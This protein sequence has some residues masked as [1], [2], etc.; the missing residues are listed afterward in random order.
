MSD[1][2]VQP[3]ASVRFI[4]G[5]IGVIL[6][7]A[8]APAALQA[9]IVRDVLASVGL[10]KPSPPPNPAAGA[11]VFPRQGFACCNLHRDGSSINDGN[12][13][14]YPLIPAGTAIEVLKY[15]RNEASIKIN[16][17]ALRLVHDYGRDQETLDQWVNKIVVNVDPT[18]RI[19]S[20]PPDVQAAIHDGKILVG[21]TREQAIVAIGYPLTSENASLDEPIWR[22]W[23]SSHGEYD[24]HF[25]DNGRLG[26]VT[27]DDEVIPLML[28][29]PGH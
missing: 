8:L 10:A 23:R 25:A 20:Y 18:P 13:A 9:G 1:L 15:G 29:Q 26:S 24:L 16:G 4:W 19:A 21:M 22:M 5:Q 11:P 17:K 2:S 14:K 3:R 27:G 12:Y 28:W 6:S 7:L